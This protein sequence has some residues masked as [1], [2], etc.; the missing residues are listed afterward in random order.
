MLNESDILA[1]T[2]KYLSDGEK[3]IADGEFSDG[4]FIK[5]FRV[6]EIKRKETIE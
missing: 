5:P 4:S 1:N 3:I 6:D 2:S